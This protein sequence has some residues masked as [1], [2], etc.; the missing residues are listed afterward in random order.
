MALRHAAFKSTG[1]A[2]RSSVSSKAA[3]PTRSVVVRASAAREDAQ[4]M[5][6]RQLLNAA[7]A[8][9]LA[10]GAG[11]LGAPAPASAEQTFPTALVPVDA[12]GAIQIK[13]QLNDYRLRAEKVLKAVLTG[14]DAPAC[15]RLVV[16]DAL[17]YDAATKTGGLDGSIVLNKEELGRPENKGLESIIEKLAKAKTEIDAASEKD[18]SGPISWADLM[19]LAAKVSTQASWTDVKRPKIVEGPVPQVD[20][21]VKLGR[22][23][24]TE[25]GPAGKVPAADASVADIT[26]Y[27]AKLNVK[28]GS[29]GSGPFAPKPPFWE[30]PTFVLWN[31]A[32]ADTEAE[33]TRFAAEKAYSGVK[34]TYDRSRRTVTRTDYE[35]DFVD[36]FTALTSLA[37]FNKT[38]YLHPEEV[39]ALK[40]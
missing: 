20:F 13:G 36:Y 38:A 5:G 17:T 19:V 3:R 28:P 16:N 7:G 9:V 2:R 22:V 25:A 24:S 14:A 26:A 29:Q 1:S 11:S 35:V 15:M 6:R 10:A 39:I 12:L 30:R 33:E 21:P 37:R 4:A 32:A 23:D 34:P 18:G 8:A 40:F 27:F 31:A